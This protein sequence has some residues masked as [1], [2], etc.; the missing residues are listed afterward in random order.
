MQIIYQNIGKSLLALNSVILLLAFVFNDP[1]SWFANDY[2]HARNLIRPKGE[3]QKLVIL[4]S[5]AQDNKSISS[6]T[7]GN[8]GKSIEDKNI[9]RIEIR[10]AQE[11]KIF[12]DGL[13]LPVD[14]TKFTALMEALLSLKEFTNLGSDGSKFGFDLPYKKIVMYDESGT[15]F[16]IEISQQTATGGG[17]YIRNADSDIY[18]MPINIL[19]LL[20]KSDP[21][22]LVDRKLFADLTQEN[23]FVLEILL[24]KNSKINYKLGLND[25]EWFFLEPE[26]IAANSVLVNELVNR[27]ASME[28]RAVYLKEISNWKNIPSL[29]LEIK[30]SKGVV[31]DDEVLNSEDL[32]TQLISE[33]ITKS[34]TCFAKDSDEN[35]ICKLSGIPLYYAMD[36]YQLSQFTDRSK[37]DFKAEIPT[38]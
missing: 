24:S 21:L 11:W 15:E 27:L 28:S 13:E 9:S 5:Q 14:S 30:Y 3:I 16:Q 22:H 7:N 26:I 32:N 18:L 1:F 35:T 36:T 2:S 37:E 38:P 17:N 33:R 20:D 12:I 29:E 4:D 25:K 10:K 31:R 6:S 19:N 23:S 8:T 34:L